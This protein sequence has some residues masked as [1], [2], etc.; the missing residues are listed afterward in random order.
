MI[1]CKTA[2]LPDIQAALALQAIDK[3]ALELTREIEQLPRHV[4]EIEKKLESHTRKLEA[5]KAA[6]AANQ[7]E[8]KSREGE[9]QVQDQKISKLRDQMLGAKTNEQYRAFQ[10]EIEYCQGEIRKAEDR[11]LDLMG[12]SESLDANVKT[13]EAA[14]KAERAQVEAE[15]T[16]ARRRTDQDKSALA[17]LHIQREAVHA[18]MAA[19]VYADYEKL[20]RTRA[21]IAISEAVDG[22]CSVC[23]IAIRLHHLQELKRDDSVKHCESCGRMLYFNPPVAAQDLSPLQSAA[24]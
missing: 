9:I 6:L 18:T 22:R 4:A 20:R 11:I 23:H 15:K 2:M 13:A 8:R 24:S 12:E 5:D 17:D 10:H 21:G 3:R 19:A 7:R 1:N 16:G 14:L